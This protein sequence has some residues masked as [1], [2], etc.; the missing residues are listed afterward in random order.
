MKLVLLSTSDFVE[1]LEMA[2]FPPL[3]AK[4]HG[5]EKWTFKFNE[6]KWGEVKHL[7]CNSWEMSEETWKNRNHSPAQISRKR[8]RI[9][10]FLPCIFVS[11][12]FLSPN[13]RYIWQK[14]AF[15]FSLPLLFY[16]S[17]FLIPLLT[18]HLCCCSVL[19]D[20][21]ITICFFRK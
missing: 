12:L 11:F 19:F 3:T 13:R 5:W 1:T 20:M 6:K 2:S 15:A 10:I 16:L 14:V 8:K 7:S 9:I 21:I 18:Q 17:L 4:G